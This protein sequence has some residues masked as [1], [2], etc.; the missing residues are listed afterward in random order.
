MPEV[1][2]GPY[3]LGEALVTRGYWTTYRALHARLGR[4]A[5]IKT[6]NVAITPNEAHR[7]ELGREAAALSLLEHSAFL[8]LLEAHD[9][10]ERPYLVL[11]EP[12]GAPLARL[13]ERG[14]LAAPNAAAIVVSI[15][16]A[17][18]H[19]HGRGVLH[20]DV[21]LGHVTIGRDGTLHLAGL[22]AP[23]APTGEGHQAFEAGE[24]FAHPENMA[25]EQ[26]R[27]EPATAASD[28]FAL[29]ALAYQLLAGAHPFAAKE[30]R[31]TLQR[32]RAASPAPLPASV[33]RA[34]VRVV[35]R[36]LAREASTRYADGE[37]ALAALEPVLAELT[38]ETVP[39][40]LVRA[41]EAAGLGAEQATRG[42]HA[43]RR[44]AASGWLGRTT[45]RNLAFGLGSALLSTALFWCGDESGPS[46]ALTTGAPGALRVLA[47]P[48]AEV[49]I[50]GA[51]YDV[52]PIGK[53]I[54]L[55]P[56]PHQVTFRHPSAP[57]EPR[58][59]RIVS[60][61]TVLLDVTMRL[62]APAVRPAGRVDAG[63]ES[64]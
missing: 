62:P 2:L 18:A 48:W 57:D 1:Q 11:E 31:E 54:P 63:L 40:L 36:C 58:T 46:A 12:G 21:A 55:P 23:A 5:R 50:D 13:L 15:A 27:G 24:A 7:R 33:P 6:T 35:E 43:A 20:G 47:S 8:R 61:Q 60:G 53:P 56:G 10:A 39:E 16:E 22:L 32:I 51:L 38:T 29:G 17:L 49:L 44:T 45:L 25:P 34:L 42:G 28:V 41:L 37:A 9:D 14:A 30:P 26:T 19:A 52:T 4:S 59:V 3:R 64:P